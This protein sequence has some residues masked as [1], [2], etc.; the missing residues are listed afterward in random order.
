MPAIRFWSKCMFKEYFLED[1]QGRTHICQW[2]PAGEPKAIVQIVHG[3]AEYAQRYSS[4]AEHL[5]K[6]GYLV[7]AEDHLGHGKTARRG[8]VQGYFN[9]GWFSAV[10]ELL[11]VKNAI[12]EVYPDTPY[13]FFGHSMGS[14]MVRTLLTDY[15]DLDIHGCVICGTGWMPDLV[16]NAGL[17]ICK[18]VCKKN[19]EKK[20]NDF[21]HKIVFGGYNKKIEHPRTAF[22]WLSRDKEQVDAYVEDPLCGFSPSAGL[23][24][25]MLTGFSHIQ[26]KSNL[27]QMNRETP[28][29]FIAGGDDPV[30][31]YGKGV[32][33]A[34]KRFKELGML[35]VTCKVYPLCRHE[36]LNEINRFEI[37]EDVQSWMEV[38]LA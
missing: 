33:K 5:N 7:V 2:E 31:D 15:P 16:V 13:I 11:T 22:D 4:F 17:G 10:E 9:G 28:I 21:L 37:F 8:S 38:L 3:I 29:L 27:Q 23:L 26:K 12:R 25:D 30:G 34:A 19:D 1:E 35:N 20:P 36:I 32:R 14:F 24:R 18:Q 6:Y